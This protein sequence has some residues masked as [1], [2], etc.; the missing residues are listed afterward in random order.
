MKVLGLHATGP[1]TASCLLIDGEIIAFA[2]EERYTRVKLASNVI[3]TRSSSYCLKEGKLDLQ[4]VEAITLGWANGKYPEQMGRFYAEHMSH[5]DKDE[6]SRIYETISLNE[7]NP[8]YFGKK[9]EI[10]Y[11]RA[12]YHG[13]FPKVYYH[14]HH[15]SHAYSVYY[16]SPFDE[17]L[18]LVVD[19]SGE[20]MATSLWVGR[21]NRI[22]LDHAYNLPHSI[23]YFYAALTEYLGFSVFTGEGKVM[24]LAPYGRPNPELRKKLN[25]VMWTNGE[26]YRVNPEYIYF[27]ERTHSLRHTDKLTRLLGRPP[28]IPETELTDWHN[29]LAWETQHKLETVVRHLVGGAVRKTGIRNIC[30]AGGVAMNCKMNGFV[31]TLDEIDNC[32]VIPA[33]N[34]A[35][36]A[37]GSALV[38]SNAVP[39]LREKARKLTVYSG[40]SYTDKQIAALLDEYKVAGYKQY[41]DEDL[42]PYIARKLKDGAIIGWFQG[43]MEVG[44]RALGN[45]SILANPAF[46]DMKDKINREVKHREPFRPF[47]PAILA[48][49]AHRYFS[50]KSEA[51]Y[52]LCHQWMLQAAQVL[53]GMREQIAAVVHVDNSIRPQV[54]S[55]ESNPRFYRLLSA[56][57]EASGVPVL[58]NTSFNVRGEPIICRP[59]EAIRCFFSTGLDI[60]VMQNVV[61]EKN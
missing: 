10:A 19:G 58:L 54:V 45:R 47:A 46:P 49:H 3:P 14:H 6:Y 59:E 17:A 2:E 41:P 18:I 32:F 37:L 8:V 30:I 57:S 52:M 36:C 22:T 4:D 9:L 15:L 23:G 12:G 50:A 56:F 11:R 40:P 5:P 21:G 42:F 25:Q 1:N 53:P 35:G 60:L 7:K 33:S 28:R 31:G 38:H 34:D 48:E 29:E 43:R 55:A 51:G 13:R 61:L 39:R 16:P 26:G 27:A 44:A 24:G 20:E